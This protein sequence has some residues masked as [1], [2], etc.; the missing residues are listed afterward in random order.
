MSKV[1][2]RDTFWNR[3][4]DLAK[5]DRNIIVVSA[6]MGAPALDKF[7]T[8]LPGQFVNVGIAEQNAVLIATG[9]AMNDKHPFVYAI[10]PFI[11]LRPLEQIRVSCGI[12]NIPMTLVGVGAG[13]SYDDS[14]PT[15]HMIE[16]I[17]IIRAIPNII[18]NSISDNTMAKAI[19]EMSASMSTTNYVR[20]DRQ[21]SNDLYDE[22]A[23]FSKGLN[24]LKE[25][26]DAC[27]V[28]TGSM[29]HAAMEAAKA[30]EK[31]KLKVGVVDLFTIP[32]DGNLL[33]QKIAA[34]KKI[35]TL[36]EHFLPG[37]MGSFVCEVL[38]DQGVRIPVKRIGLSVDDAYCYEYGGREK[39]RSCYGIDKEGIFNQIMDFMTK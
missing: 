37:G 38:S 30:L 6:D 19:A 15:H 5:Q 35:I 23:D 8:D 13:F 31:K 2:Q 22:K 26:K 9:L 36:E 29:V 12:M 21:P 16:D 39:I 1:T 25:G 32:I 24:V 28:A 18:I 7:R 3:V 17:A 10:A 27:I 14:G 33:V 34:A 20:I 4:Y 11:T